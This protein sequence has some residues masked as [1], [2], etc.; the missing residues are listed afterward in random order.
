[1][2][3]GDARESVRRPDALPC[4]FELMDR[5]VLPAGIIPGQQILLAGEPGCGKSTLMLQTLLGFARTG[6]RCVYAASEEEPDETRRRLEQ[7]RLNE[8]A[9]RVE[10][11]PAKAPEDAFLMPFAK[12]ERGPVQVLIIDSLQ[13]LGFTSFSREPWNDLHRFMEKMREA[14]ITVFYVAHV[15]KDEKIAGPKRTEH[16]VD[17]TV[18]FARALSHRLIRV[19]KNRKGPSV[20]E[21]ILCHKDQVGRLSAMVRSPEAVV[22][23]ATAFDDGGLLSVEAKVEFSASIPGRPRKPA[24]TGVTKN[25]YAK[26]ASVLRGM[27][28]DLGHLTVSCSLLG[29]RPYRPEQDLA[30]AM[31]LVAS[32]LQTPIPY[33]PVFCGELSL[34]GK[35]L[36]APITVLRQLIREYK[37]EDFPA[38]N[39]TFI[40]EHASMEFIYRELRPLPILPVS[41]LDFKDLKEVSS[42]FLLEQQ[43]PAG[44]QPED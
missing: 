2:N 23:K 8:G 30:I 31:S 25:A 6:I 9:L 26:I 19:P 22:G 40:F 43:L 1:M 27:G 11:Y 3:Q 34:G 16:D 20:E 24:L 14:K 4:Q 12:P 37:R 17:T 35:V 32:Y 39:R 13:G 5:H 10:V 41:V 29:G 15:T 28:I 42:E 38:A 21:P 44:W 7:L 36:E 33:R 18:T